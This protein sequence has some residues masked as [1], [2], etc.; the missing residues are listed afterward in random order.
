M[1]IM[2]AMDLIAA[3]TEVMMANRYAKHSYID[4]LYG[5]NLDGIRDLRG[6]DN[7]PEDGGVL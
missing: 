1:N 6:G 5:L 2:E 4:N 3:E 7:E